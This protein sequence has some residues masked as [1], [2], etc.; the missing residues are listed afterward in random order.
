[1]DAGSREHM[2]CM[3]LIKITRVVILNPLCCHVYTKTQSK[4]VKRNIV[5]V[6]EVLPGMNLTR[7]PDWWL[8]H[9]DGIVSQEVADDESSIHIDWFVSL[10]LSQEP[11]HITLQ[12]T[13]TEYQQ[14]FHK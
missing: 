1:M 4:P 8:E 7:I 5:T 9:Q 14:I 2:S 6:L 12:S 10:H 13:S 11:Q 3:T